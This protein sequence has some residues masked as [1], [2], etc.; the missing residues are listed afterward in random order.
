MQASPSLCLFVCLSV[1]LSVC[2]PSQGIYPSSPL[3]RENYHAKSTLDLSLNTSGKL[4]GQRS[5]LS[6]GPGTRLHARH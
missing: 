3:G 5:L 2:A 4:R 6:D 1:C